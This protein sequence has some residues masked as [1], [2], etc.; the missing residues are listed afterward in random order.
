VSTYAAITHEGAEVEVTADDPVA[1]MRAAAGRCEPGDYP[2]AL[3]AVN[4]RGAWVRPVWG[5]RRGL[6]GAYPPGESPAD[7]AR[8]FG[9][10]A[11]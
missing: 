11:R 6:R 1:G 4:E 3:Y 2:V 7:A 5:G 9:P 10:G 8:L